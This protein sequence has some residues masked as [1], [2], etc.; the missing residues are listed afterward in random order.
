MASRTQELKHPEVTTLE[1]QPPLAKKDARP[2]ARHDGPTP[3][4]REP[5]LQDP[6]AELRLQ[7]PSLLL[8]AQQHLLFTSFRHTWR[9]ISGCH[10]S[11]IKRGPAPHLRSF[12]LIAGM[13]CCYFEC[14]TRHLH[15]ATP[16]PCTLQAASWGA[17]SIQH[18]QA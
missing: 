9:P 18:R 4:S 16:L 10:M 14:L 3:H 1:A 13:H 15:S 2:N 5:Q 7:S 17:N 6:A 11:L 8:F 12:F